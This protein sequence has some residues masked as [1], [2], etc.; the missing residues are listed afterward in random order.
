MNL[1]LD[2]TKICRVCLKDRDEMRSIYEECIEYEMQYLE[3]ILQCCN[4]E[5]SK[6]QLSRGRLGSRS[7][8]DHQSRRF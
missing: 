2:L 1:D 8:C 7:F 3:I 5:V 6:N 4:V